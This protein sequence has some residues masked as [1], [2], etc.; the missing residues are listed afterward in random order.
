MAADHRFTRQHLTLTAQFTQGIDAYAKKVL[1]LLTKNGK[2]GENARDIYTCKVTPYPDEQLYKHIDEVDSTKTITRQFMAVD[3]EGKGVVFTYYE[4]YQCGS[5]V[6][7]QVIRKL[8]RIEK[9][10]LAQFLKQ[11][12]EEL[13][14]VFE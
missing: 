10:E 9:N 3:S 4:K 6:Q 11:T 5:L 1:T 12:E 7:G 8:P 2:T 14:P 13:V